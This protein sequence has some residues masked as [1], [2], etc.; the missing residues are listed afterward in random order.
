[1]GRALPKTIQTIRHFS[2]VEIDKTPIS[3]VFCA[4]GSFAGI[5][6]NYMTVLFWALEI[7]KRESAYDSILY[8]RG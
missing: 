7:A 1:M 5:K 2:T 8:E 6:L 3:E 4:G